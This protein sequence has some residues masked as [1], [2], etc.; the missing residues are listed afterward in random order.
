MKI[1]LV[2]STLLTY[3]GEVVL[4]GMWPEPWL[5]ASPDGI[6]CKGN[7]ITHILGLLKIKCPF[8]MRKKTLAE[9]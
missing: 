7:D 2:K 3:E 9:A 1:K 8:S 5:A 4:I 6:I